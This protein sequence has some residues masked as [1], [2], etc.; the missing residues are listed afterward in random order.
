MRRQGNRLWKG[1]VSPAPFSVAPSVPACPLGAYGQQGGQGNTQSSVSK[2]AGHRPE[3]LHRLLGRGVPPWARSHWTTQECSRS[4]EKQMR[5][6][7]FSRE[8]TA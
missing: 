7:S 1:C 2:L 5:P 4:L 8:G 6:R 3:R